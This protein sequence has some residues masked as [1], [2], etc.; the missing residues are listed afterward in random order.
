MS[1]PGLRADGSGVCNRT[2]LQRFP[3]I[4]VGFFK[5][6][7]TQTWWSYSS[8]HGEAVQN[9]TSERQKMTMVLSLGDGCPVRLSR[10][11]SDGITYE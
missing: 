6:P 4:E 3:K 10:S 7:Q 8:Q 1:W 2:N 9:V 5:R 11:Q